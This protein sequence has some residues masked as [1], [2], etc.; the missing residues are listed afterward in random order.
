MQRLLLATIWLA[1]IVA[2]AGIFIGWTWWCLIPAVVAI[3]AIVVYVRRYE[4][5]VKQ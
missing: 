5:W 1:V 2:V 3:T 4:S